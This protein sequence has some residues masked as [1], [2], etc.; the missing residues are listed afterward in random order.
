MAGGK[1][2]WGEFGAPSTPERPRWFDDLV[3]LTVHGGAGERISGIVRARVLDNGGTEFAYRVARRES[4]MRCTSLDGKVFCIVGREWVWQLDRHG[5]LTATAIQDAWFHPTPDDYEFG[6]ERPRPERWEGDD[7]TATGPARET[8]FLGRP[9]WEIELVPP[10]HKPHPLQMII[11]RETGL[12][13]REA[14]ASFETYHEWTELDMNSDLPDELFELTDHD[15][16]GTPYV[17]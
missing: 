2:Y 14:N 7:F 13:L 5:A 17:S 3:A 12:V 8:E 15:Q 9:A 10:P 16:A 4:L 1:S 6:T 11:D